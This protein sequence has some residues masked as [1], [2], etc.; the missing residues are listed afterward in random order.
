VYVYLIFRKSKKESRR[1]TTARLRQARSS[2]LKS[3]KRRLPGSPSGDVNYL[4]VLVNVMVI[5]CRLVS[6][7][8]GRSCIKEKSS[9]LR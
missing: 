9:K 1:K 5:D 2:I 8:G 6:G 7:E 4:D 3:Q